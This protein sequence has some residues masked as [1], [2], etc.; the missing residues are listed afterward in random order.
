MRTG[1]RW[2]DRLPRMTGERHW[3][4]AP[5]FNVW[6]FASGLVARHPTTARGLAVGGTA[7]V[8]LL[9]AW[10][11]YQS[12]LLA[13][14]QVSVDGAETVPAGMVK[15][16]ADLEG[17]SMIRPDFDAAEERL[18]ELPAVKSVSISRDLLNGAHIE[19]VER[20][21]WGQWEAGGQRVVIDSDGIV[22]DVPPPPEALP[23]IVQTD[24]TA[25]LTAGARVDPDVVALAD[26]LLPIA[27]RTVGRGIVGM[28]YAKVGG[29]TVTFRDNLRVTFGDASDLEYKI[30]VL[31]ELLQRA[32]REERLLR[33][34]DLRFGDKV[35]VVWGS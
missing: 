18:R 13:V 5:N 26:E 16:V 7:L 24:A 3:F 25:A 10:W 4:D 27:D 34:V 35:A 23:V 15:N 29:L 21:P 11:V 17:Q 14:Q 8:A 22:L 1:R 20:E 2:Q 28:E 31:Y 30:A 9:G 33:S 12:P 32:L 19:I 6:R